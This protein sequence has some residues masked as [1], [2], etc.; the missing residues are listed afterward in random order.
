MTDLA[1]NRIDFIERLHEAFLVTT[2]HGAFA[3][4]SPD[5]VLTLFDEYMDSELSVDLFT[6]Q[7]ARSS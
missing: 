7:Y 2:G 5:E 3:F 4:I 1:I 6:R